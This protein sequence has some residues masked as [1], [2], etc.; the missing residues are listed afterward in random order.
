MVR[1]RGPELDE[2]IEAAVCLGKENL[3]VQDAP[4]P[5]LGESFASLAVN[6]ASHAAVTVSPFVTGGRSP[7]NSGRA[8]WSG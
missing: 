3:P 8:G 4:V 1:D 2:L 6:A 7:T 5:P